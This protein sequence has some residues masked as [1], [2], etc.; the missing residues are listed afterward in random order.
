M[1][2]RYGECLTKCPIR[3]LAQ[4]GFAYWQIPFHQRF[5]ILLRS[6]VRG[7]PLLICP[8]AGEK[9]HCTFSGIRLTHSYGYAS[10]DVRPTCITS[11]TQIPDS[12]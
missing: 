5:A 8:F 9:V 11:L 1:E 6:M 10:A 4:S 3:F 12:W 2:F 7:M